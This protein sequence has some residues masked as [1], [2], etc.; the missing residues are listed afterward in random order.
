MLFSANFG[1]FVDPELQFSAKMVSL[2]APCAWP[3]SSQLRLGFGSG[4]C[5]QVR[6][7]VRAAGF[8]GRSVRISVRASSSAAAA[9][10][11][12]E[13]EDRRGLQGGSW[14]SLGNSDAVDSFSGWDGSVSDESKQWGKFGGMSIVKDSRLLLAIVFI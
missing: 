13:G 7:L 10:R 1:F 4:R 6:L 8:P 9:A 11:G 12:G 2:A 3:T 5:G 14:G